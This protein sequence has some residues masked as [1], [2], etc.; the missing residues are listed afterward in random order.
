MP[1]D[2]TKRKHIPV[3]SSPHVAAY[4]PLLSSLPKLNSP[5]TQSYTSIP[6]TRY[7]S[8]AITVAPSV[9]SL[10][11]LMLR[12][13]IYLHANNTARDDEPLTI[14]NMASPPGPWRRTRRFA[15]AIYYP[16][17]CFTNP[18][19]K[20]KLTRS[21]KQKRENFKKYINTC[22]FIYYTLCLSLWQEA[23]GIIVHFFCVSLH[24]SSSNYRSNIIKDPSM[25]SSQS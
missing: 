14:F 20:R 15:N 23:I 8:F 18:R 10:V 2:I 1:W 5:N 7:P 3:I 21:K 25:K 12:G 19:W 4:P 11:Y 16:C 24:K 22:F 17:R 13:L 9:F 6:G